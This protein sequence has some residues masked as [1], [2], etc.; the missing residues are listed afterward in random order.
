MQWITINNIHNLCLLKIYSSL[1]NFNPG[2]YIIDRH[3][4]RIASLMCKLTRAHILNNSPAQSNT[5]NSII[6][7]KILKSIT[8]EIFMKNIQNRTISMNLTRRNL[9]IDKDK[10]NSI[11]KNHTRAYLV[12]LQTSTLRITITILKQTWTWWL[13]NLKHRKVEALVW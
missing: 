6:N 9:L 10:T 1:S 5:I 11:P 2:R 4:N 7:N 8:R 3:H 12:P 13:I